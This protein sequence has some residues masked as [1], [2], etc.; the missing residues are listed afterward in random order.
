MLSLNPVVFWAS[1]ISSFPSL[2]SPL[3]RFHQKGYS[4]SINRKNKWQKHLLL[5]ETICQTWG[6]CIG[7]RAFSS[8]MMSPGMNN[9]D[10]WATVMVMVLGGVVFV[11]GGR[12][13]A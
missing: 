12:T 3:Q 4:S 10:Q 8:I 11:W 13:V 9:G 1:V 2:G 6:M 5:T 7:G